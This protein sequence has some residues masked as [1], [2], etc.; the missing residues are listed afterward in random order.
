MSPPLSPSHV[1]I[2]NTEGDEKREKG[3]KMDPRIWLR[4]TDKEPNGPPPPR[5]PLH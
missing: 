4:F 5:T 1:P 2:E 3:G